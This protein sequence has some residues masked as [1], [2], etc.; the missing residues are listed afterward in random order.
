MTEDKKER[1][2]WVREGK[3]GVGERETEETRAEERE[4]G[5]KKKAT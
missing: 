1:R 3:R 5:E 2:C 4:G